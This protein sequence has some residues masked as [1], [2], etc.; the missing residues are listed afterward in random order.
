V[1]LKEWFERMKI[2]N[3]QWVLRKCFYSFIKCYL[4]CSHADELF[5]QCVMIFEFHCM[6]FVV[7]NTFFTLTEVTVIHHCSSMLWNMDIWIIWF[8]LVI[9]RYFE[10]LIWSIAFYSKCILSALTLSL[11]SWN[12]RYC[13]NCQPRLQDTLDW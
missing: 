3:L 10:N 6:F 13:E 11:P 1:F 7:M 8:L 9:R 12:L 4:Y 5:I 2:R